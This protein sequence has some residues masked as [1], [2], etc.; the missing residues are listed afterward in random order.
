M[1]N[2]PLNTTHHSSQ[3]NIH[4]LDHSLPPSETEQSKIIANN[5]CRRLSAI[6]LI[7]QIIHLCRDTQK[8]RGLGMGLLAG[9]KQFIQKFTTLQKQMAKRIELLQQISSFPESQLSSMDINK[10]T[11]SWMTIREGWHDD[12]VLENF[13]FH[14]HFIEQLLAIV[15]SLSRELS[16]QQSIYE[17]SSANNSFDNELL[18]FTCIRLPKMIEYLGMIRALSTHAAAS[19]RHI[20]EHDKKLHYFCHCVEREKQQITLLADNLHQHTLGRHIPSLL[21]LRTHAFKLD[22]FVVTI[23]QKIIGQKEIIL[24]SNGIFSLATEIMDIYWRVVDDGLS[25]LHQRQD[26]VLE[27]W[28]CAE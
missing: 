3:H 13:Q 17:Q 19:G 5:F 16:T 14:C 10:I 23:A 27:E 7:K 15:G 22:S 1:K 6:S 2:T 4:C 8:H 21:V 28:Y 12:S 18:S 26:Q 9:N 20:D 25:A 24:S 11:E